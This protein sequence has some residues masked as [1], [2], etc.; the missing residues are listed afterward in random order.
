MSPLQNKSPVYR[1]RVT[2]KTGLRNAV[3]LL[4]QPKGEF[5]FL[6]ETIIATCGS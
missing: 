2:V 6:E 4:K 5:V 3:L 1:T